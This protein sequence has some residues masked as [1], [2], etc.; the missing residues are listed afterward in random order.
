MKSLRTVDPFTVQLRSSTKIISVLLV[1]V[2]IALPLRFRLQ[3]GCAQTGSELPGSKK[4][5]AASDTVNCH[6]ARFR[7]DKKELQ[8]TRWSRVGL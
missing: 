8:G 5:R 6:S 3:D 1:L 7:I 2:F 4:L